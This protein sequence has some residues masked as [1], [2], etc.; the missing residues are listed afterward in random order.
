M[1]KQNMSI[2][3]SKSQYLFRLKDYDE[4]LKS[5]I[6]NFSLPFKDGY[7]RTIF[8]NRTKYLQYIE[9]PIINIEISGSMN[10]QGQNY[11]V[12]QKRQYSNNSYGHKDDP[13]ESVSFERH[14]KCFTFFSFLNPDWN[15]IKFDLDYI[16]IWIGNNVNWFPPHLLN[17]YFIAIHSPKTFP[18]LRVGLEFVE[19]E[20]NAN[21]YVS[22]SKINVNRYYSETDS[23]CK[24]YSK[25]SYHK[26]RSDCITTC[27]LGKYRN[28]NIPHFQYSMSN[29][30][31][32][33]HVNSNN[34]NQKQGFNNMNYYSYD[35]TTEITQE[36]HKWCKQDC[37]YSY[38]LYD[39]GMIRNS[40]KSAYQ[41]D[42]TTSLT[43]QHNRLPDLFVRH[44]PETTFVS[45]VG[46]FGGLLGMWLGINALIIFDNVY[47]LTNR[48]I[49]AIGKTDQDKNK[50]FIQHNIN[51]NLRNVT[52]TQVN[53][54][55]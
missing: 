1:Y 35:R 34:Y 30:L 52:L 3:Y 25:K 19:I 9:Y 23:N 38:Y 32:K 13:I 48:V 54:L 43:I 41:I 17:K 50:L 14:A 6:N 47:K 26:R 55:I 24:D 33:E 16:R 5:I 4:Y 2:L 29:L 20:P 42:K 36:C 12:L 10:K 8:N 53:N 46:N 15:N 21:Y 31:R 37:K 49:K 51:Y 7:F 28:E 11:G 44:I 45:F 18:E 22:F 39:I 40:F 27:K